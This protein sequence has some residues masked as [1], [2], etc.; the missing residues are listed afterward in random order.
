MKILYVLGALLFLSTQFLFRLYAIELCEPQDYYNLADSSK[1]KIPYNGVDN[2]A[3]SREIMFEILKNYPYDNKDRVIELLKRK[4]ELLDNHI[5]Q[6]QT[7]SQTGKVKA[8][9]RELKQAKQE[10]SEQS[11]MVNAATR[12]N[13]EEVRDRARKALEESARKLREID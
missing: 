1:C 8:D 9:I 6:R 2:N 11:V 3:G 4:I 10:L 13:W 7:Q 5:D 12:E